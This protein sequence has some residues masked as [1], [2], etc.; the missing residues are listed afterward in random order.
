M[1][2]QQIKKTEETRYFTNKIYEEF[3]NIKGYIEYKYANE[4]AKLHGEEYRELCE[5]WT[6][7]NELDKDLKKLKEKYDYLD[8]I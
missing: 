5:K 6:T 4:A 7:L 8:L 3:K 1:T 2:K